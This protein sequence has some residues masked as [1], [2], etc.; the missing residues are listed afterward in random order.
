M[1]ATAQTQSRPRTRGQSGVISHPAPARRS[2]LADSDTNL[3]LA[4]LGGRLAYA[5][6]REK[7]TQEQLGDA[8]DKVRGT[9]VAYETNK[10][11][12]PIP[13]VE[14]LAK[15]LNV[16]AAF[17]AFGEH[18]VR[19]PAG[20]N[21]A[22][23]TVNIDEISYGRDGKYTSGTYALPRDVAESYVDNVRDLKVYVLGHNAEAFNLRAGDRLF[24]DVGITSLSNQF[25]TYLIEALGGLEVVRVPAS[26]TKT[27]VVMVEGPKGDKIETKV[28][29]LKIIGVV[30]STLRKQ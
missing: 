11:M 23:T 7:M 28:R 22:E 17:L 27:P 19:A 9:I 26:F 20:G 21:A 18:G 25:D 15:R 6:L 3:D 1:A 14:A 8:I 24:A 29:D 4:S 16:S 5:R 12:P 2:D 10:I 30:V 13:I